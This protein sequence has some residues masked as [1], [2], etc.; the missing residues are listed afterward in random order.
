MAEGPEPQQHPEAKKASSEAFLIDGNDQLTLPEQW[1]IC[2]RC[3]KQVMLS[4]RPCPH[5]GAYHDLASL[6]REIG[7]RI[8]S[9]ATPLLR[10]VCIFAVMLGIS[11]VYGLAHRFGFN[12]INYNEP[13]A[14]RHWFHWMVSVELLDT[15]LVL[16]AILWIGRPKSLLLRTRKIR[17]SVWLA[18][19]PLLLLLLALNHGYHRLLG[20]FLLLPRQEHRF[21]GRQEY[22][23]W[24]LLTMCIQ[25]AIV[26]EFFFRYLAF[27]IL[28]KTSS[29]HAAVLISSV[30]FGIAHVFAPLSIP[31]L[32]VIGLALGYVRVLSGSLLLPILIHF[33]HNLAITLYEFWR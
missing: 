9:T 11:L 26:E 17:V 32:M 1:I 12:Q 6:E 4:Q 13:E 16:G 10:L 29:L 24:A 19:L 2:W 30:M 31:L 27:G 5:C 7:S 25:P 28:T 15:A 21:G 22:F 18:A 3:G 23:A 8:E 20:D 33:G 14:F